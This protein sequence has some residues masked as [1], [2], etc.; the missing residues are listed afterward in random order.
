MLWW[1]V[2]E[3]MNLMGD[4]RYV[5]P[6]ELAGVGGR[7]KWQHLFAPGSCEEG[8]VS[9]SRMQGVSPELVML[10]VLSYFASRVSE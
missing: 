4:M 10:M 3:V 7:S 9:T 6:E 1:D 2:P 5:N 8:F